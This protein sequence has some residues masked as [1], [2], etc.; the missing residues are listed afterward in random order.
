MLLLRNMKSSLCRSGQLLAWQIT[1]SND[2]SEIFF[3]TILIYL[4]QI[5]DTYCNMDNFMEGPEYAV[6]Q[7]ESAL[8]H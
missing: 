1:L 6:I 8:I 2:V 3:V 5:L 4:C 7:E